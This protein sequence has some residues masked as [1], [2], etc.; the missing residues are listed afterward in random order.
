MSSAVRSES[1]VTT[2]TAYVSGYIPADT[3]TANSSDEMIAGDPTQF[4]RWFQEQ[5]P[6]IPFRSALAVIRLAAEKATVPFIARYRKEQTGNIDE[7]AIGN[8]IDAV[9]RWKSIV[10]R[11]AFILSEIE[12][13]GKLTPE[14][15][16]QIECTF[17]LLVLE[18]L[19]LPYKRKRKTKAA[20]ARE[21]GLEPL[22]SWIWECAHGTPWDP[23]DT[24]ESKALGFVNTELGI[25]DTAAAIQG[26]E[27]ILIERISEVPEL[28]QEVRHQ[29]FTNGHVGSAKGEK[30][31]TPSKFDRYFEYSEPVSALMKRE[32]SHRYLAIRRGE[33]EGELTLSIGNAPQ[34]ELA[35]ASLLAKYQGYACPLK[36]TPGEKQLL[37]S[38]RLAFKVYVLLS[39]ENEIHSSLREVADSAAIDVFSENVRKVLLAAPLGSKCVLGVDPGLRTGCKLALINSSGEFVAS[40]VIHLLTPEQQ[41]Q[42][43]NQLKTVLENGKVEAIA[44]GNGTAARETEKFLRDTVT[45][46]NLKIPVVMVSE[47]G[48]SIYSAS[49]VAREEFPDLDVTVR[50]AISIARRLQDPLAELVKVDPK[51]IG[52]GQYQHDVSQYALKSALERVVESCVNT[53]GVNVNTASRHLLAYVSGIGPSLARSIVEHR[54]TKGLF[55]S[56][57]ELMKVPYFGER[58]FEQAAGFLR[59]PNSANP[60]D[61]T[62][63]HPERYPALES[64]AEQNQKTLGDLIGKG[65]TTLKSNTQLKQTLGDFTFNDII[66]ELEKP[67]RDPRSEF[68]H[69]K[70]REDIHEVSDLKPGMVCTGVVT[71]VTNFGAFVDIGVHQDG[72]VHISQLSDS[73]VKDPRAVVNAGDKVQVRVLEV[74]LEKRQIALTMKKN[75]ESRPTTQGTSESRGASN[76]GGGQRPRNSG[77]RP[78]NGYNAAAQQQSIGNNP[79]ANLGAMLKK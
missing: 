23:Q 17:D 45:K 1:V 14:L 68:E 46:M 27:S 34:N 74:N 73:F 47:S 21:A 79:F 36:G 60:L 39:I 61:N 38:A 12:A 72:L 64:F 40:G 19:Y 30:A 62:G 51:S 58:A 29:L 4:A 50:G 2:P 11:K 3:P 55:S 67:G 42:S 56:R 54:A 41:A 20:I 76:Y 78:S 32:N 48:A 25:S 63:V 13:Q 66:Q 53:V 24:L 8:I 9:A 49:E 77:S 18:D 26:A 69:V 15:K 59:I 35:M 43:Y 5:F 75:A 33:A 31:K 57:D 65:V 70:Y 22:A 37:M 52:V 6:T 16:E 28:R 7:V 10:E 44:V 71:N